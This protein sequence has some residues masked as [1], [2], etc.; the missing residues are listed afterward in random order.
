[1]SSEAKAIVTLFSQISALTFNLSADF[2]EKNCPENPTADI[3]K[4]KAQ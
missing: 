1:V 3:P 2:G 4:L